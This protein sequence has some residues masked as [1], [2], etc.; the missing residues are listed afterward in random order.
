MNSKINKGREQFNDENYEK[1]LTYFDS[2][3]DDDEDYDYVLIFKITCLMEL[4]RYDKALFLIDSLLAEQS[5]SEFLCYE[6]VRCHIALGEKQEAFVALKKLE[7]VIDNDNKQVIFDIARFY[8]SL[9]DFKNAL[10][11]CNRALAID[12]NFEEALY[13][14]SLIGIALE[15]DEIVNNAT[16]KLLSIS[17]GVQSKII[18][19]FLLKLYLGKYGECVDIVDNYLYDLDVEESEMLKTVVFNQLCDYLDVNIHLTEEIDLSINDAIDLLMKYD[20][21]GVRYGVIN[22]AG[23]M[24]M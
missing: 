17:G 12:G 19:V 20:K 1:A 8:K 14:K 3:S 21:N 15:N 4:E 9:N 10:I 6:K 22:D 18:P 5:D 23:Y 2:I 7:R 24:I 16:D 11:F 13:E